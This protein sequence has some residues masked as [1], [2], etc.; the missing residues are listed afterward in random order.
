MRDHSIVGWP[1]GSSTHHNATNQ[2]PTSQ[3]LTLS[4]KH[5]VVPRASH[6]KMSRLPI[7]LV[8]ES[9]ARSGLFPTWALMW[10]ADVSLLHLS[11]FTAQADT[12]AMLLTIAI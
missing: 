4:G 9:Q 2:T 7:S 3:Q 8:H 10:D 5:L 6:R 1:V 11:E 12:Q